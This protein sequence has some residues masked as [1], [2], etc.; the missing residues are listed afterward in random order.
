MPSWTP[1]SDC[2]KE[3]RMN[4]NCDE[5][6][7]LEVVPALRVLPPLLELV[8]ALI[9]Q[10]VALHAK[11]SLQVLPERQRGG[12]ES[13]ACGA[14]DVVL[15]EA[16]LPTLQLPN[17]ALRNCVGILEEPQR[18]HHKSV[19]TSQRPWPLPRDLCVHGARVEADLSA[20]RPLDIPPR[21]DGGHLRAGVGHCR[22]P[23]ARLWAEVWASAL[24]D[25]AAEPRPELS[26]RHRPVGEGGRVDDAIPAHDALQCSPQNVVAEEVGSKGHLQLQPVRGRG[27][28]EAAAVRPSVADKMPQ[29]KPNPRALAPFLRPADPLAQ[30]EHGQGVAQVAGLRL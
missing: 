5:L 19:H 13:F 20:P 11:V 4:K 26:A 17:E 15:V 23:R 28:S 25:R 10:P 18:A 6:C 2:D 7:R 24:A 14:K 27:V 1:S 12:P 29:R 30:P 3:G 8:A 22:R 16:A 21:Q 9:V